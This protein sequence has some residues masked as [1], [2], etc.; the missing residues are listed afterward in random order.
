MI[1]VSDEFKLALT[2]SDVR[3]IIYK[4]TITRNDDPLEVDVSDRVKEI[5]MI[6]EIDNNNSTCTVVLDNSDFKLS[7]N[8]Y[9]SEF[10]VF[11]GVYNP[12][13]YPNHVLRVYAGVEGINSSGQ[14][15][16]IDKAITVN[17]FV[18]AEFNDIEPT[19]NGLMLAH[20]L[21]EEYLLSSHET[22][23]TFE[24]WGRRSYQ[25]G[26]WYYYQYGQVIK[27]AT[28]TKK[29]LS[30]FGIY[31]TGAS[32]KLYYQPR[33]LVCVIHD[34]KWPYEQDYWAWDRYSPI[35]LEVYP[36]PYPNP[37][38]NGYMSDN[39]WNHY[40]EQP[41]WIYFNFTD[42][43]LE[44]NKEYLFYTHSN[45]EWSSRKD[46]D[47]SSLDRIAIDQNAS[48]DSIMFHIFNN[49]IGDQQFRYKG[50]SLAYRL[51][52]RDIVYKNSGNAIIKIDCGPRVN[53]YVG[54]SGVYF[55]MYGN[56]KTF[57]LNEVPRDEGIDFNYRSSDDGVSWSTWTTDLVNLPIK[58][59]V[60]IKI[61]LSTT[62]T[63][64]S[65]IIKELTFHF[66]SVVSDPPD[67][68]VQIFTGVTGDDIEID[69][70]NGLVTLSCRDFSKS[71][72]D[73]FIS[74]SDSYDYV[75]VEDVINDLL[76]KHLPESAIMTIMGGIDFDYKPT[77]YMIQHFQIR[78]ANLWDSLQ[79]L[80]N[81]MGWYLTF[82]ENGVLRLFDRK[83]QAVAD[84]ILNEDDIVMETLNLSDADIRNDILVKAETPSG[85]IQARAT[86]NESIAEFGRRF[87]E[88]DRSLS[89]YIYDYE[90]ANKLATAILEDLHVLRGKN[91]I[92][93]PFF[94]LIQLGDLVAI[95][96]SRLGL[97]SSNEL[98]KVI[99]IEHTLSE[100][101]KQTV[102]HTQLFKNLW[103][104]VSFTPSAPTNLKAEIVS[105]TINKYPGCGWEDNFRI[106]YY[107]KISWTVPTKNTDNTDIVGLTGFN[108]YRSS[109]GTNYQFIS[110]VPV[111]LSGNVSN[112][113]W[114]ID[115]K[116][117]PG[118][119]YYKVNAIN[120]WNKKSP[121]SNVVEITVPNFSVG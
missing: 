12:L 5:R 50:R 82:D 44:P 63:L 115:Y 67:N 71:L 18:E 54:I 111:S 101:T 73:I 64:Y 58:R 28:D 17:N 33:S 42:F 47:N 96:N 86:D 120:M 93:M 116:S 72:Q 79:E 51:Y 118:K 9:D 110:F 98:Y 27:L 121:Y 2:Q 38:Y 43:Y 76:K 45:S 94:P 75:L 81:L 25:G 46:A 6:R 16:I 66:K 34:W 97:K 85:I 15:I 87:M 4:V 49:D 40:G 59:Y 56:Q 48:A 88:V 41:K 20:Y 29:K 84:L 1:D 80:A 14:S 8:Q 36:P 61:L 112:V 7:P 23:T 60:Q 35:Y 92:T 37:L 78:N 13:I 3:R 65:P 89:S 57:N 99:G 106:F 19:D 114:F 22:Y 104:T 83:K 10:N 107:P 103:K 53:K 68:M 117:G 55:D 74:L 108:V 26:Y 95:D 30:R 77:Y 52:V 31:I 109:D 90:S 105:R 39:I 100:T 113:N 69:S 91:I 24:D 119:F 11:K 70:N 102:L 32:D 62:N 21:S